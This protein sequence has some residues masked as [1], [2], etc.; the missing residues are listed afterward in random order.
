M[1]K[2]IVLL[3]VLA[4]IPAAAL[5]LGG[6]RDDEVAVYVQDLQTGRV[7]AEHRADLPVNPAST[8]KLVTAFAA[9]RA[10]GGDFR[11]LTEFKSTARLRPDGLLE[12]D[13]YWV[14]SGDPVFDQHDLLEMQAQL[15]DN[16]VKHIGGK[17]T[18][19]RRIWHHTGTA[20][21]FA[22]DADR[23][24]ATAP[25]PQML[26]YKV[27]WLT[28]EYDAATGKLNVKTSP[29]LPDIPLQ[30]LAVFGRSS[31]PCPK[32]QK[33]MWGKYRD[34]ILT[35]HGKVPPSCAGKAVYVNMLEMRDFSRLS[36]INQWRGGGGTISDGLAIGGTP[37]QARTL[38]RIYSKP[39]RDILADMNKH[40]NNLI[41]RTV[42]LTLGERASHGNAGRQ[43]PAAAVQ[44]QLQAAGINTAPLVLENG[45]GLSRRER[46]SARMLGNMLQKA[47]H[48]RFRAAFID[49]LPI[50]G[51]DGTLKNR[52][53]AIGA[54]LRLKTGTLKNVR[55]LAGYYLGGNGRPPMAIVVIINSGR[56]D[57]LLGEMDRL[58]ERLINPPLPADKLSDSV[59]R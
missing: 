28:P 49:T 50:A 56:S 33:F 24:F 9:L 10:L 29:P 31:A 37:P 20:A 27:V 43:N 39:L 44:S 6:I 3:T 11:W 48:S 53:K 54:P 36:F 30:N 19:D 17:L 40:S 42:F 52:F 7:V 59:K 26:A 46:V 23:A 51:T 32:P 12:G 34:G 55:A 45:S 57:K 47:Y 22:D 15:R 25:D 4:S 1:G 8:M 14:G 5:D 18:F 58:V 35:V 13:L 38:A 41:A 16:G 21:D 2:T